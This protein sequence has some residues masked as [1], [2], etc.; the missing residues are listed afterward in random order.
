LAYVGTYVTLRKLIGDALSFYTVVCST[1]ILSPAILYFTVA[2]LEFLTGKGTG[3]GG[4]MVIAVM[5]FPLAL[6]ALLALFLGAVVG[7]VRHGTG[8]SVSSN[9]ASDNLFCKQC[10]HVSTSHTRSHLVPPQLCCSVKGCTCVVHLE[11]FN[12]AP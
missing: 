5:G 9:E 11:E 3:F 1:F 2:A 4:L 6:L 12:H 7:W 10:G 8:A